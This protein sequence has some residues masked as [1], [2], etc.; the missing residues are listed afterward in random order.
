[1]T[2]LHRTYCVWK[3]VDGQRI[4]IADGVNSWWVALSIL[5]CNAEAVIEPNWTYK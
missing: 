3:A 4:V 2:E 1:M 5:D